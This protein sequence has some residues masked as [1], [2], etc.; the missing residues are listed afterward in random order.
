MEKVPCDASVLP[1]IKSL[2]H[3]LTDAIGGISITKNKKI[4]EVLK[5]TGVPEHFNTL[6]SR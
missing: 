3:L 4:H 2:F 1:F 5:I 6:G